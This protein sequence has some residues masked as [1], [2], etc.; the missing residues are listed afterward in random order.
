MKFNNCQYTPKNRRGLSSLIG[1]LLLV[2]LMVPTFA[3]LGI[4]LNSQTDI[5]STGREVA[6][7][8]L[9]KQQEDLVINTVSQLPAGFLQVNLTNNGQKQAEMF[10]II[11]LCIRELELNSHLILFHKLDLRAH[12]PPEKFLLEWI[13]EWA[14]NY[15]ITIGWSCNAYRN[16]VIC[17]K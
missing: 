3:V 6:D 12:I 1:G 16:Q 2:L 14:I 8:A 13:Y 4:V 9:E 10:T 7:H 17:T 11:I 5:V 15:V